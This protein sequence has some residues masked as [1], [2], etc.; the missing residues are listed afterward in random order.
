MATRT[1]IDKLSLNKDAREMIA[2]ARE[3]GIETV[4]D[5]LAAQQN[6][7][8]LSQRDAHRPGRQTHQKGQHQ[9]EQRHRQQ[10]CGSLMPR[11]PPIKRGDRR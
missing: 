6:R 8:D 2:R 7:D 1:E 3:E 4:W 5:R 9:H 11:Q 10:R